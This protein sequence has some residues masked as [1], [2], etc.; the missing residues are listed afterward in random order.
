MLAA[1]FGNLHR[2][3]VRAVRARL[4][5]VS[6]RGCEMLRLTKTESQPLDSQLSFV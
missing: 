2:D 4:V 1:R 5:R 3:L 6:S